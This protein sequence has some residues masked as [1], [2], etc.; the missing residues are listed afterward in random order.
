MDIEII[1]FSQLLCQINP[2]EEECILFL[3]YDNR[4]V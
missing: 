1:F 3:R 4:W 2:N